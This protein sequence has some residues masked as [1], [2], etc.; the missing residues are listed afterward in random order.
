M[1]INISQVDQNRFNCITAKVDLG[2]S[3]SVEELHLQAINLGVQLLIVRLPTYL[4]KKAQELQEKNA[5][6]TDTLVFYEKNIEDY[7]DDPLPQGYCHGHAG[8]RD[9]CEIERVAATSFKG[10]LGHY[11]ADSRLDKYDCDQIYVSWAINCCNGGDFADDVIVIKKNNEIVAFATIKI[12]D[13]N[14]IDGVLYAVDPKYQQKGL[15]LSLMKLTQN[16][17]VRNG[18]SRMITS[19]QI[20]NLAAQKN[21]CRVGMNPFKSC[22]TYH[23]WIQ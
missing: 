8:P 20:Y 3:D 16:W 23:I 14:T 10:Y 22:Y 12:V 19:T 15:H 5:I 11:H 1:K 4:I 17:G 7:F 18:Y 6:L 2:F 13:S 9:I 21:W